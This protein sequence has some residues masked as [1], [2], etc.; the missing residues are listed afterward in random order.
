[1]NSHRE[2]LLKR[3]A[4]ADERMRAL[5]AYDRTNPLF[6]VNLT[7]QQLKVL[8]LLSRHDGIAS[9][10]LTRRL[11]VSLATLSGIVDRLVTQGYVTRTE[12][13]QDRRIR[14]IHLSPAGRKLLTEIA[15]G[16]TQSQQRLLRRLDD[17]TLGM[18]ASVLERVI[19]AAAADIAEQAAAEHQ[20]EDGPAQPSDRSAPTF[21]VT[22]TEAA[23]PH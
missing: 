10:E 13:Q 22:A 18:L 2:A 6:S 5:L 8:M 20:A 21:P 14:R 19:E 1:M 23:H 16:G 17:E 4:A 7:M 12:D 11:G 9:A 3:V 15:D